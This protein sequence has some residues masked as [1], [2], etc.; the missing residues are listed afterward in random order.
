M[1][2]KTKNK[3]IFLASLFVSFLFAQNT[4]AAPVITN[5]SGAIVHGQSVTI[6]GNDFGTKAAAAPVKFDNFEN[7]TSATNLYQTDPLWVRYLG[8]STT[9]VIYSNTL[10]H[11]G[12]LSVYNPVQPDNSGDF[13]TNYY[14]F[15]ATD[16]VWYSYWW[17]TAN[18]AGLTDQNNTK[19]GRIGN[20]ALDENPYN[21]AGTTSLTTY[22]WA[23]DQPPNYV[24]S[25][26]LAYW[27]DGGGENLVP[28]DGLHIE[29]NQ[30]NRVD[31]HKKLSSPGGTANGAVECWSMSADNSSS[32]FYLGSTNL[33]NRP[34]GQTWQ[35]DCVLLGAMDGAENQHDYQIYID[36][37]YVDN[38]Q[39]RVEIC[40]TSA[41]N[42]RNH[43]EIQPASSWNSNG[44]NIEIA[45]NAGTFSSGD[46]YLFVIDS[47]GV[48]NTTGYLVTFGSGS[49]DTTPPASPIGL[50]VT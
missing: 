40:D 30:W 1:A 28:G 24:G 13:N 19:L 45:I 29:F 32:P 17:R 39:S 35:Q 31:C 18:L 47:A 4:F 14:I 37:V 42:E 6:S 11:S 21:G 3:K 20:Y 25:P 8:G 34:T 41:W 26:Y 16:E 38:T 15:P 7:G 44:Q 27:L 12:T 50:Q 2:Q 22:M 10:A 46:A 33:V 5:V 43:C 49:S 36:D 23:D 9:G 48:A